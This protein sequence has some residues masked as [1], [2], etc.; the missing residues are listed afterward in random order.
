MRMSHAGF[1][2]WHTYGRMPQHGVSR[3]LAPAIKLPE[4]VTPAHMHAPVQVC[5]GA[6]VQALGLGPSESAGASGSCRGFATT[7]PSFTSL[8][9]VLPSV[10]GSMVRGYCTDAHLP[11]LHATCTTPFHHWSPLQRQVHTPSC[12][13]M[14]PPR[15]AYLLLSPLPPA[16]T[17]VGHGNLLTLLGSQ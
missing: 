7:R 3:H 16:L 14:L 12:G 15:F 2:P 4:Q 10:S 1:A 6:V 5:L 11:P 9:T 8:R 13:P 17:G